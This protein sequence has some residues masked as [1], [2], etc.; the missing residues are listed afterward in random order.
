MW[1]R[2]DA[3][4]GPGADM[5]ASRRSKN[6]GLS[7][8]VSFM[9]RR[10]AENALRELDGFDWGGSVLRV[11][12]S[13]AVPVAQRAQFSKHSES[14]DNFIPMSDERVHLL[15][16]GGKGH[17]R[18]H[19]RSRSRSPARRHH[20][21]HSRSRSRSRSRD[22]HRTSRHSPSRDYHQRSYSRSRYG[23][24][25]SRSP[26]RRRSR[27]QSPARDDEVTEK[28]IRTVAA[29]VIGHGEDGKYEQGLIEREKH[30][31]R[32]TFMTKRSVSIS[33]MG[34]AAIL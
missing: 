3:T 33:R 24:S 28:F 18:S 30:N 7:G 26:Y 21:S 17:S 10:D 11:G 20:P 29:E 14:S 25:H 4:I 16:Y 8:F 5:T 6:S 34:I 1:P 23:R 27:S 9:K 15:A 12:W 22:R 19:S 32:Y 13:K 31:S 2:S